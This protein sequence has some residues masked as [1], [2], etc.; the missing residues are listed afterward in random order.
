MAATP[1]SELMPVAAGPADRMDQSC[2]CP[3]CGV[4]TAYRNYFDNAFWKNSPLKCP[5]CGNGLDRVPTIRSV[6]LSICLDLL[7]CAINS[8]WL[9]AIPMGNYYV[10]AALIVVSLLAIVLPIRIF[11]EEPRVNI[12]LQKYNYLRSGPYLLLTPLTIFV[13][14]AKDDPVRTFSLMILLWWTVS[15]GVLIGVG[16]KTQFNGW[17]LIAAWWGCHALYDTLRLVRYQ[18]PSAQA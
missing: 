11:R 2:L 10:Y 9:V 1:A 13:P 5:S 17:W 15:V 4:S 18:R 16:L 14:L 12:V 3:I 7:A 8:A 6:K